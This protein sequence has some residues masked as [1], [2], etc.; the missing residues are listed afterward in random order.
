MI[1]SEWRGVEVAASV[2][3]TSRAAVRGVAEEILQDAN[4]HVP[5]DPTGRSAAPGELRDSGAVDGVQ[6]R[7]AGGLFGSGWDASVYYDTYYAVPLHE[8]P[9]FTFQ[10]QGEGKWLEN[11]FNRAEGP[12][13]DQLAPPFI[14]LFAKP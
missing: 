14:E 6:N 5:V 12:W 10:G 11:A 8:H 3:A 4:E 2:Q 13:P 7:T 1:V 9:E